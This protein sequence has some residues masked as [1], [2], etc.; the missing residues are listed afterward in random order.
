MLAGYSWTSSYNQTYLMTGFT[1]ATP[2]DTYDTYVVVGTKSGQSYD[3]TFDI[4]R[5]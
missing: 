5:N 2:S 3:F 4:T 1:G